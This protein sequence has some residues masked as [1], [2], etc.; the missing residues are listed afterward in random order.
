MFHFWYYLHQTYLPRCENDKLGAR[1]LHKFP[2]FFPP[3]CCCNCSQRSRYSHQLI[4]KFTCKRPRWGYAFFML[5][6]ALISFSFPPQAIISLVLSCLIGL[7]M[8]HAS[9]L[10][11]EQVS[12]T[13]FTIIGILCKI[14]TLAINYTI[15]DKHSNTQGLICLLV[16][17]VWACTFHVFDEAWPAVLTFSS[18]GMTMDWYSYSPLAVC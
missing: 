8:S 17:W 13:M 11:R 5:L 10:L 16:W 18:I 2:G 12:G 15:W 1:V 9:Y 6:V 3:F 4:L 14:I 7:G